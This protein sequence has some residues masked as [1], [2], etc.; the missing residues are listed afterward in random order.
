MVDKEVALIEEVKS[1]GHMLFGSFKGSGVTKRDVCKT[2]GVA[3]NRG[4]TQFVNNTSCKV[5]KGLWE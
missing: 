5:Y 3:D 1:R 2:K 4:Q